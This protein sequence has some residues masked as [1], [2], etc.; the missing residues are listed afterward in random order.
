MN[1]EERK[2]AQAAAGLTAEDFEYLQEHG[3][4]PVPDSHVTDTHE[5]ATQPQ[6]D[7]QEAG[8]RASKK[9]KRRHIERQWPETGTILEADYHGTHYDAE[10][11]PAPQ[12][13]SGKA[14]KI[15]TGN[16]AGQ[17][18]HSFSGSMLVATESQRKQQGL[19]RRGLAN[20]W[21]FWKVKEGGAYESKT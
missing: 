5:A 6:A 19:G 9:R 10:V 16:A 13:K 20:G 4:F 15:L 11:I 7:S 14:I 12:Y 18:S 21:S 17:V 3:M 8:P 1:A 2:L